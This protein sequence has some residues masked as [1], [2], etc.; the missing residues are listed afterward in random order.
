MIMKIKPTKLRKDR[1]KQFY[2][3]FGYTIRN[4]IIIELI[5]KGELTITELE[6]YLVNA[7]RNKI[8]KAS[9]KAAMNNLSKMKKP[10]IHRRTLNNHLTENRLAGIVNYRQDGLKCYWYLKEHELVDYIR[11][12]L[13]D[14][15]I[16]RKHSRNS[17][18]ELWEEISNNFEKGEQ[19]KVKLLRERCN[20][21]TLSNARL[22]Q[23]LKEL[24]NTPLLTKVS[25]GVYVREMNSEEE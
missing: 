13:T 20:V 18:G 3:V 4:Q 8:T 21:S 5:I 6:L 16:R 22:S 19:F 15:P 11:D 10:A 25:R 7:K 14:K 23:L 1:I 12:Y 17:V 2:E 24:S 9:R